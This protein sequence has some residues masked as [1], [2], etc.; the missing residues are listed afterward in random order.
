MGELGY[1]KRIEREFWTYG[2]ECFIRIY[3]HTEKTRLHLFV[4][5]Q[6]RVELYTHDLRLAS[7]GARLQQRGVL[8][9]VFQVHSLVIKQT[10]SFYLPAAFCHVC[11]GESGRTFELIESI[12][13]DDTLPS[14]FPK[15]LTYATSVSGWVDMYVQR[16][17]DLSATGSAAIVNSPFE[18]KLRERTRMDDD[19]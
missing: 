10:I 3:F 19:Q 1:T 16:K 2:A 18:F 14:T 13:A 17:P 4:T 9:L 12:L 6:R 7:A 8:H 5:D 11:S 15:C